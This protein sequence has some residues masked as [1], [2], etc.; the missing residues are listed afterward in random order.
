[1]K[2][3]AY[4]VALSKDQPDLC[5][6]PL[7]VLE[8]AVVEVAVVAVLAIVAAVPAAAVGAVAAVGLSG[9]S[10]ASVVFTSR[11]LTPSS[12]VMTGGSGVSAIVAG[13]SLEGVVGLNVYKSDKY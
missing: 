13:I 1:M 10:V 3:I 9:E 8:A 7:A 2:T 5:T 4:L 11:R 6:T 12:P